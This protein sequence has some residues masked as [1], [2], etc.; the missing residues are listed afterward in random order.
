LGVCLLLL[1]LPSPAL[2]ASWEPIGPDGGSFIF[3]VTNPA[4]ANQVT[5]IT[6]SPSPSYVW[7]TGDG[8]TTWTKIG[9]IPYPYVSDVTAFDF[10]TLYAVSSSRCY[11]STDGGVTWTESRLPTNAGWAYNVCVDPTDSRKVYAAGYLY[12]SSSQTE[13]MAFFKSTDGGLSWSPSSW[14]SF[15][16]FN[17]TDM[18]IAATSPSTIYVTAYKA[19]GAYLY[20]GLF[21]SSDAGNTWT[22]IS[23]SV[24][25]SR[26]DMFYAVAI[27]PTDATKVYVGGSYLYRTV[28]TPR[29]TELTWTRSSTPLFIYTIGIDP[30]EPSK[31]YVGGYESVGVSRDYGQSWTLR[32]NCVKS[33]AMHV[34]AALANPSTV[35]VSTYAGLYKSPDSGATW[36]SAHQG[37][38]AA[39]IPALAV[40]PSK[41]LIQS[42]GYLMAHNRSR[43]RDAD[44]DWW[45][46]VTPESCGTVCD[47]LINPDNPD[48]VLVLEGYG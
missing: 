39:M 35:Y 27:D 25:S 26:S 40:A 18:A 23:D 36:A 32:S 13:K 16:F 48:T 20:P 12:Q 9:E 7:R 30:V 46:V 11:R 47:I 33:A 45:Y 1:T 17:P 5:A 2:C 29:G 37:L 24:D 42:N 34:Q 6:T 43:N 19:I 28:Y 15:D 10:E 8:G 4:D 38:R 3:S 44:S 14:F 22:D 31:I 21:K 41:I